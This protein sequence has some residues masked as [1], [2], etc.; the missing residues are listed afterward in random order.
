MRQN[1]LTVNASGKKTQILLFSAMFLL[2]TVE[3]MAFQRNITR[4]GANGKTFSRD[5]STNRTANGY[6]RNVVKTGPQGNSATRE[7]SGQWDA[8]TKT[9]TKTV[10]TVGGDQ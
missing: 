2:T 1:D 6:T 8:A 4:T 10:T 3:A 5:I 7:V 9:W